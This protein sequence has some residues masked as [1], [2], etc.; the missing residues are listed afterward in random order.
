MTTSL[1]VAQSCCTLPPVESDYVPK[2][3]I[4]KIGGLDVY[5]VGPKGS[6]NA[7]LVNY[8]IFG[9]QTKQ[10]CDILSSRGYRVAMPDLCRGDPW[11]IA[12]WP[13]AGGFGEV[14]A[15]ISKNATVE[16]VRA[17]M[18]A[19]RA[20]LKTEGSVSFGI[21][22]FCWGGRIVSLIS[23][24]PEY[25]AIALAHPVAVSLEDAAKISAPML[26]LPAQDDDKATFEAIF[27]VVH[28]NHPSS[29]IRRFDDV[30]HGFAAARGDFGDPLM[31]KRAN[32]AIAEIDDF[33][34]THLTASA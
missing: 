2:G 33:F 13:P 9:L 15:H 17:D 19:T 31:A 1:P 8:D 32:E 18:A 11:P 28:K 23:D 21:L 22:G 27:E 16:S 4:I 3:E 12:Q 10:V 30:P 20:F 29:K 14:M 7:V 6:K 5:I 25:A 26:C 34:T 24:E